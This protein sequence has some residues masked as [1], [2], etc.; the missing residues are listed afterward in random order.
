MALNGISGS[1][2]YGV[3]TPVAT[4]KLGSVRAWDCRIVA[5]SNWMVV[6][7]TPRVGKVEIE[8]EVEVEVFLLVFVTREVLT[9][10]WEVGA[11][12]LGLEVEEEAWV[13]DVVSWGGIMYVWLVL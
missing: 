13:V 2:G 12:T 4:S 9:R 3:R 11:R 5:K 7:R 1:C 10:R 6:L 8:V